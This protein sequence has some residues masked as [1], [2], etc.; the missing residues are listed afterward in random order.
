M[1]TPDRVY[2]VHSPH[3]PGPEWS[4]SAF[5]QRP[6]RR[7]PG[8]ELIRWG[9]PGVKRL[10]RRLVLP[11]APKATTENLDYY[12]RRGYEETHRAK[13]DDFRRVFFRKVLT[14]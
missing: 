2:T 10:G 13:Q 11:V 8:D 6:I 7:A 3:R 9:R 12:R 1:R 14:P 5:P 4:L